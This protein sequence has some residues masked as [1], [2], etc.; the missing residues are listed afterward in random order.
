VTQA[1]YTYDPQPAPQPFGDLVSQHRDAESSFYQFDALGS[2]RAL[3]DDAQVVTDEAA[4]EAFGQTAAASGTT[5]NPFQWVGQ[6]GY[7]VDEETGLYSLRRRQHGSGEG[8]FVSEDPIGIDAGDANLYRVVRNNPI[9]SNDP[10]GLQPR[11]RNQAP[12]PRNPENLTSTPNAAENRARE[13][14]RLANDLRIEPEERKKLDSV[15]KTLTPQDQQV[16][17]DWLASR[18]KQIAD[19]HQQLQAEEAR[20][21]SLPFR[22]AVDEQRRRFERRKEYQQLPWYTKVVEE[23]ITGF[24]EFG[25]A[26]WRPIIGTMR[27]VGIDEPEWYRRSSEAL[28]RREEIQ[29]IGPLQKFLAGHLD[30]FCGDTFDP[31][32]LAELGAAGFEQYLVDEVNRIDEQFASR[33]VIGRDF[34][35]Q[36]RTRR[37]ELIF[38]LSGLQLAQQFAQDPTNVNTPEDFVDFFESSLKTRKADL[39]E[40]IK[41]NQLSIE[42]SLDVR[43]ELQAIAAIQAKVPAAKKQ[44]QNKELIA[45]LIIIATLVGVVVEASDDNAGDGPLEGER[46]YE[47]VDPATGNIITD[48]DEISSGVLWEEK[49]AIWATDA[50]KWAQKQITAKAESY[51]KARQYMPGYENAPIGFRFT[52]GKPVDPALEAAIGKALEQLRAAHPDVDFIVEW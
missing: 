11:R 48:I 14:E 41:L 10:S 34:A 21:A 19:L 46:A 22:M 20:L 35:L 2:S 27:A 17:L 16:V 3:T 1:D 52:A 7:Y 30:A 51:L 4:Y 18:L 12:A 40:Q 25:Q 28:K 13:L 42:E 5:T 39:E 36:L 33:Q 38:A 6:V 49:S 29:N 50:D 43:V 45:I 26:R 31:K 47:V 32:F 44:A 9:A 15:F 8:R 37:H 24:L 23:N